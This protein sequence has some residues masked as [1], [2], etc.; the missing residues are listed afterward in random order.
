MAKLQIIATGQLDPDQ[1]LFAL[2]MEHAGRFPTA[3][4]EEFCSRIE[5]LI[6]CADHV[7]AYGP[8]NEAVND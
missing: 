7:V 2:C 8:E 5:T 3:S 1:M 6:E 4:F